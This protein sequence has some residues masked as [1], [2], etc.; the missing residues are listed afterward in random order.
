MIAREGYH[1]TLKR[2]LIIKLS[3]YTY[4]CILE[5]ARQKEKEERRWS[6]LL[7]PVLQ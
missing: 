3:L 6:Y 4:M 7:N 2:I 5:M 1:L